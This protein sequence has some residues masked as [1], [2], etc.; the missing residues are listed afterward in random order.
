MRIEVSGSPALHVQQMRAYA[1]YRAFSQLAVF[2]SQ[3]TTVRVVVSKSEDGRLTACAMSAELRH[4]GRVETRSRGRPARA[5]DSAARK[6][7]EATRRRLQE[8]R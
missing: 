7:A 4:G 1:E 8:L 2:A 6:L 5:V 3:L